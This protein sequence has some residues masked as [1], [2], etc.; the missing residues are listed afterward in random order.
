MLAQS[1]ALLPGAS[2]PA[3][4]LAVRRPAETSPLDTLMD[5]VKA[6]AVAKCCRLFGRC[7]APTARTTHHSLWA[8]EPEHQWCTPVPWT[9]DDTESLR[10]AVGRCSAICAL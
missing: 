5:E 1:V 4:P 6:P 3:S 7:I 9:G 10:R 2:A 8:A